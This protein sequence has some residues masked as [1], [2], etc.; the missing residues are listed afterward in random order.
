MRWARRMRRLPSWIARPSWVA[1]AALGPV[2]GPLAAGMVRNWRD[3]HRLL[4]GL[5]VIA[6]GEAVVLTPFALAHVLR[7]TGLG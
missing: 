3:G 7:I 1:Y 2:S 5:Y 6:M 4:A